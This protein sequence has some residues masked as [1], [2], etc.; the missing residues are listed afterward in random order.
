MTFGNAQEAEASWA[1]SPPLLARRRAEPVKAI[2][3]PSRTDPISQL[4]G[5]GRR[6]PADTLQ[7]AEFAATVR[8]R[9]AT[10]EDV[11]RIYRFELEHSHSRTTPSSAPLDTAGLVIAPRVSPYRA[12]VTGPVQFLNNLLE[13]WQLESTHATVLLG[14]DPGDESYAGAV[15]TGRV[16]LKGRDA[17][18]RI[19]HLYQIRK[20]LSALF[21][22]EAVENEWLREP[23]TLLNERSPM[24]L[25][26]EGSMEHLL[27]VREY[28]DAA[29]G[30]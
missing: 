30:R 10:Q 8:A 24:D 9:E 5:V 2:V 28:V 18:D 12:R 3:R 29:A 17:K 22:D 1:S 6:K 26:L 27:L 23:H 25:M 11:W 20:T 16:P 15:L 14:L 7:S 4:R 19:A 21:R 13:S